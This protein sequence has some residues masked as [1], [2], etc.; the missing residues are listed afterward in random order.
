MWCL[1]PICS[2]I[3]FTFVNTRAITGPLDRAPSS[4]GRGSSVLK[5]YFT[6][7]AIG[8]EKTLEWLEEFDLSI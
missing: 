7:A 4:K 6:S 1:F 5:E 8:L 2:N 3:I